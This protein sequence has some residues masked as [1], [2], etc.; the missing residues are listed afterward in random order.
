MSN[1]NFDPGKMFGPNSPFGKFFN[2]MEGGPKE[3]PS[4]EKWRESFNKH[5]PAGSQMTPAQFQKFIKNLE[6]MMTAEIKREKQEW[7]KTMQKLKES[8]EGKD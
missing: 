7:K 4:V 2:Q 5:F 6:K 3:S 8:E 1:P